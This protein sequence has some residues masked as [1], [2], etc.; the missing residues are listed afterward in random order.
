MRRL[1]YL[2]MFI[3]LA[4]AG[5]DT[6]GATGWTEA[7]PQVV[8]NEVVPDTYQSYCPTFYQTINVFGDGT[9]SACMF[10]GEHMTLATYLPSG[11][12]LAVINFPHQSQYYHLS[13]VCDQ[14]RGC[15]YSDTGDILVEYQVIGSR[16]TPMVYDDAR[17]RIHLQQPLAYRFDKSTVAYEPFPNDNVPS[18]ALS[19]NGRWLVGELKGRG[20]GLADLKHEVSYTI[21]L[22][23][24]MYGWG[25]DPDMEFAV[26]ND[27]KSVAVVGLNAGQR[28]FDI[29]PE[30]L[31][32]QNC[33]STDA[34]VGLMIDS[35][36][37]ARLPRFDESGQSLKMTLVS[38]TSPSRS[39]VLRKDGSVERIGYIALGD[40]YS[41]GEGET[42]ET[43]YEPLTNTIDNACHVSRRSYPYLLTIGITQNVACSGATIDDVLSVVM[44]PA[45][46]STLNELVAGTKP[47]AA[48]VE[49]TQPE[50]VTIG[51][52]GND[53]GLMAK[54]KTCAMPGSCDW[55]KPE[56]LRATVQEIKSLFGR[57]V[58]MYHELINRAPATRFVAI[59]YPLA[60][61]L[62][63]N[64]D[65]VTNLLLNEEERHFMA[66]GIHYLNQVIQAAAFSVGIGY[67]DIEQSFGDH[68]LCS[69]SETPAMNGLR[70]GD[71]IG[72]IQSLPG[73]RLISSASFHPTP[74][75]HKLIADTIGRDYGDIR[76]R[77][78]CDNGQLLCP[79]ST[80]LDPTSDYWPSE[81]GESIYRYARL[82]AD[83]LS[84]DK[85]L[86]IK[87]PAWFR[88]G[89][90]V[91]VTIQSETIDL[92][93]FSADDTGQ[94]EV[95]VDVPDG[96]EDGY[97]TLL[98]SGTSNDGTPLTLYQEVA[99]QNSAPPQQVL[100]STTRRENQSSVQELTVDQP[101]VGESAIESGVA[102]TDVTSQR[103]GSSSNFLALTPNNHPTNNPAVLGQTTE[104]GDSQATKAVEN[105]TNFWWLLAVLAILPVVGLGLYLAVKL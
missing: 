21:A 76:V 48:F 99:V 78:W 53:A 102:S 86:A 97:H 83:R 69:N 12:S 65:L 33:S 55:V 6:V 54:L 80:T 9:R 10:S 50:L 62:N 20:I 96:L 31:S 77:L 22:T 7:P 5:A 68:A 28:L 18:F 101:K 92:G 1:V 30:C 32:Q 39:I 88:A 58:G 67:I 87:S 75:G 85:V 89:D 2:L 34:G 11:E 59:S 45:Q 13:G 64:C 66:E 73:L 29:T 81:S 40:S 26:S 49:Q 57:L 70:L 16:I 93:Q 42:D 61:D 4:L 38:R 43:Y 36:H 91:N 44:Y 24:N 25:F 79:Q 94:I 72:P 56:G 27:G 84:T 23:G 51:V 82:V 14:Y 63:G 98:L 15:A 37:Y 41:S 95:E 105:N 8:V 35:L 60:V 46:S 3:F 103:S 52:G 100:D 90:T 104:V 19:G 47:Q 17:S 71:D 74:F